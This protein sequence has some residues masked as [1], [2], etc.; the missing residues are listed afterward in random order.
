MLLR[1]ETFQVMK[2]IDGSR[3]EQDRDYRQSPR[4]YHLFQ[5][6]K[7]VLA[8]PHVSSDDDVQ[9]DGCH[10]LVLLSGGFLRQ[11]VLKLVSRYDTCF[12]SGHYY[13]ERQLKDCCICFNKSFQSIIFC[14][15]LWPQEKL[16]FWMNQ[17]LI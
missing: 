3:R 11:L 4:D 9:T 12:N 1:Q 17:I 7:T 6:L 10:R 8:N 13:V 15:S 14:V 5:H 16:T 2:Q